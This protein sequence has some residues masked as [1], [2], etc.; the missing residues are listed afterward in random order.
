[1][2]LPCVAGQFYDDEGL[3]GQIGECFTHDLGPG[4][5]PTKKRSGTIKAAIAPHA[6]YIY[7]GPCAAWAYKRIAEAELPD[8]FLM[9]G[10]SHSGFRTCF[11][12][13]DWQTP[14]GVVKTDRELAELLS[15]KTAVPINESSHARE[16]SIE[17][18][19]PFLQFAVKKPKIVPLMVSHDLD[20]IELGKKLKKAIAESKKKICIVCSSDFT[21]Y[22]I[23]YGFMPFNTN[24]KENLY[25]LDKQAIDLIL[26]KKSG[27]FIDFVQDGRATICGAFPIAVLLEATDFEKAELLKYYT[28]GDIVNDYSSAVGYASIIFT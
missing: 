7:S 25:K 13:E 15:G 12:A 14:L 1:M 24:R 5:L 9:L 22:G 28:S 11:S 16:H 23:N 10:P 6:G 8:A 20:P 26:Q 2:R 17:V 4:A 3:E 27:K 19:L 21:H 18:Q